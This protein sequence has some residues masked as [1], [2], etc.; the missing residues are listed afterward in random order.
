[1]LKPRLIDGLRALTVALPDGVWISDLKFTPTE[2]VITGETSGS[3]ADLV[4][5][6]TES[7]L[8]LVPSLQ[9][10]VSRTNIGSERFSLKFSQPRIDE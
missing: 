3:A 7:N 4:L 5:Q 6:L 9:G 2:F 10:A 8:D 1:M